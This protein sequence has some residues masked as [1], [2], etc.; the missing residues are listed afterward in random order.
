M[1]SISTA[2]SREKM[3][4]GKEL[5]KYHV[6]AHGKNITPSLVTYTQ[7]KMLYDTLIGQGYNEVIIEG[8]RS[9]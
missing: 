3:V 5:K 4:L 1:G 8:V 2:K 7:A 6:T 9:G